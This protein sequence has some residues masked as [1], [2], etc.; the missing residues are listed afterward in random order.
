M[1]KYFFKQ[2]KVKRDDRNIKSG[3]SD[4]T[5]EGGL[6]RKIHYPALLAT[7]PPG[8]YVL[9]FKDHGAE[10]GHTILTFKEYDF[11]AKVR[12]LFIVTVKIQNIQ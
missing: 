11:N 12:S 8:Q 4:Q 1:H 6:T 9:Y 3:S 10:S 5:S 7:G 2:R